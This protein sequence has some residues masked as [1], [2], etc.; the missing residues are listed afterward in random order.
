MGL[1]G[2]R[3]CPN[4]VDT[5]LKLSKEER[6]KEKKSKRVEEGEKILQKKSATKP[7]QSGQL[8]YVSIPNP[9]EK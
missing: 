2:K 8:V 5:I 9:P 3:R 4:K 1:E 6:R 7:A